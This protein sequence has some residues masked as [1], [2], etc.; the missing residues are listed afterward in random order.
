MQ[1]HKTRLL[2]GIGTAVIGLSVGVGAVLAAAPHGLG[3]SATGAGARTAPAYGGDGGGYGAGSGTL[4]QARTQALATALAQPSGTLTADQRARLAGMA[5][6]EKVALDAYTTFGQQY[7]TP[8]WNN[9]AA[10]EAAHLATV[11]T[12]L[13]RHGIADPTA[14]RSTGDFPSLEATDLYRSLLA[15]GS[16]SEAAAWGVGAVVE[17]DDIAKLDVAATGV[18][19]PDVAAVYASLRSASGQ[20]L[21]S[22][23]RLLGR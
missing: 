17:N 4:G 7:G 16:A 15:Q 21:A 19:A 8:V 10:S 23:S 14:G 12:L 6:E 3:G 1:Q 5:E 22:F 20:H 2:V 9:V 11:R 13:A 18:T